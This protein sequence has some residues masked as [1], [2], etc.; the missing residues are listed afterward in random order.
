MK[1]DVSSDTP[2]PISLR[3]EYLHGTNNR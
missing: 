2:I 1:H 3:K